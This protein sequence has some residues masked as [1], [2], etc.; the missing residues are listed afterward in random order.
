ML[1]TLAIVLHFLRG[2][3]QLLR[4]VRNLTFWPFILIKTQASEPELSD[5]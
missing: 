4:V 1:R 5:E 2:E 3:E